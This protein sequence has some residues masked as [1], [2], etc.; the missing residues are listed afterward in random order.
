MPHAL[1][2]ILCATL[3]AGPA[4]AQSTA[5]PAR[6]AGDVGALTAALA[7]GDAARAAQFRAMVGPVGARLAEWQ[8]LR[9]GSDDLA[10]L[11]AF[12]RDH[13]H[14]PQI[15][16]IQRRAEGLLTGAS[17]DQVLAFFA[18]RAPVSTGGWVALARAF[19]ARGAADSGA[20]I[21][22][23]LWRD[24][25]LSDG[26]AQALTDR[27]GPALGDL[28]EVRLDAMLWDGSE[29]DVRRLLGQV[30][31]GHAALARAR[32][33]LQARAEGVTALI[34]AVPPELADDPGLAH[35]RF[36]W[37]IRAGQLDE[38][39]A[40][41]ATRPPEALGR[42][43]AW[44]QGRQRL[45]RRAMAEGQPDLAYALAA[46]HGLTEG[47]A[48][49]DLEWLAGY[50]AL[51]R[52]NRPEDARRHFT[53]LRD[54]VSSPISLARGGYWEGV[55]YEALNQT[56]QA[57]AAFDFAAGHQTAF[58]GQLAAERLGIPLDADLIQP[59]PF[60]DWRQ[61]RLA[62]SDLVQAA[63]LLHAA[64]DWH[65]ARRF[66]LHL[67]RAL[68][69]RDDLGALAD[70][71]LARG[72]PNFA[73][74]IAKIAVTAGH[75]IMPAYFPLTGL[76]R[77]ELPAPPELVIAVARRESEFDPAVIS[78][79][80]ARGLLQVLPG[81]GELTARRLGVAYD[82][83]RLTTDPAFNALMGAGYLDQMIGEFRA[84]S[85]VAAAYNAGPGRPRRWVTE[86]GDPRDPAIDPVDWV[87][88]IPFAETRNYVMR[89]L[90]SVVIYR[91]LLTGDRTINLTALL[92]GGG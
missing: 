26:E 34:A 58:Y 72:E 35:D 75:V 1:F 45:V 56:E 59:A 24:T 70:L 38:A 88:A 13:P 21:A 25:Q 19:H 80:D 86:F 10:A 48:M 52:L 23:R 53:R 16:T 79:A 83:A 17:D 3:A 15:A 50:L 41:L 82:A 20:A 87:E 84:W 92:R 85:L 89:V 68:E 40:L 28:H 54:R 32:L 76:E 14:W 46:N 60:P 74:N 43:E 30:G 67:A 22:R 33:A 9:T 69:D 71:W 55:A 5:P 44:A 11:E 61:T 4:L 64:G 51:R 57:R 77:A 47:A 18:G 73:V 90:E 66:T 8:H 37:R 81:T 78:H 42:P 63:L 6:A 12:L 39:A 49:V 27:F 65:E 29:A 62:D 31:P 2:L 36:T 91:A 7:Q